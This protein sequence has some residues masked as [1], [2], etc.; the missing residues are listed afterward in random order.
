MNNQI[1][2]LVAGRQ[3]TAAM[4]EIKSR[5]LTDQIT[6]QDGLIGALHTGLDAL[7]SQLAYL[8]RQAETKNATNGGVVSPPRSG[9]VASRLAEHSCDIENACKRISRLRE[10]LDV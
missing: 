8:C 4:Q 7:E 9:H 5:P 3:S 10:E 1:Q 2:G 6:R